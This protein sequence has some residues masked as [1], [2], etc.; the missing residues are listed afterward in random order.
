VKGK[1][2]AQAVPSLNSIVRPPFWKNSSNNTADYPIQYQVI[3]TI[4]RTS[5]VQATLNIQTVDGRI[6]TNDFQG[7]I[8]SQDVRQTEK[9]RV[10][11]W[12]SFR[13]GDVVR[14]EVVSVFFSRCMSVVLSLR[15]MEPDLFV[16]PDFTGRRKKLFPRDGE[17]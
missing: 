2:T 7:V 10:K 8:R 4:T 12:A 16:W 13:P 1:S 9:D 5:R 3:G 14:A 17:E 6:C 11:I 15:C